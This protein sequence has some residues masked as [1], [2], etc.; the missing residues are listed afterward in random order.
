MDTLKSDQAV[1]FP[2]LPIK[3]AVL[4]PDL[5]MP[6][7]IGRPASLLAVDT[8]L[9]AESRD[10]L[11]LTQR[12]SQI[13][14][15]GPGDVHIVGTLGRIK[16]FTRTG[17]RIDVVIQ[18]ISRVRVDEFT[19]KKPFLQARVSEWRV[20][21]E[22]DAET[23]ALQR[24]L[25]DLAQKLQHIVQP[26]ASISVQQLLQQHPDPLIKAFVLA[27]LSN[28]PIE[29]E[30]KLLEA[31]SVNE[32]LKLTFDQL[33]DE[34][35]IIEIKQ[36]IARDAEVEMT[37]EKKEYLLRQQMRAIQHELGD[38]V[39]N[40]ND[41]DGLRDQ[42]EAAQLP[43]RVMKDAERELRRL[44]RISQSSP[45]Y[46]IVRTYLETL[47][48][49]PWKKS[50]P[51]HFDIA[52]AREILDADHYGIVDVKDRIIEHLAVK[53]LNPAAKAPI[54]CFVGPPG[55]GKTSLGESI[56]RS[57]D[58]P[59]ERLSLGGL[60]D[61][62]ELRGHRRTYIGAMPGRI[63]QAIRKAGL[64]NP[65]IM[66]DELDKL[67]RDYRGDPASALLE[68][69]DPAQNHEFR[70]NYLDCSF[71]LS[72]VFFI[73]TTNSLD[74][75]PRPLLD[76]LEIIRIPGY[77]EDEKIQI[78][79]RY[80]VAR[81]KNEA[82]LA[83]IDVNISDQTLLALIRSYTRESGVRQL[84]RSIG[85]V[86]RKLAVKVA[87]GQIEVKAPNEDDLESLL[88]AA[89]YTQTDVS[90]TMPAG[91]AAGLAW[92]ET[93]GDVLYIEAASLPKDRGITLTGQLGDIMKESAQTALSLVWT[94][95][96]KLHIDPE[97]IRQQGFHIHLPAGAVPKDGPSAGITL[98]VAIASLLSGRPVTPGLAMTGEVTLSG[99]VIAIGG[100][101][102]KILAAH[103]YG[104]RTVLL[105]FENRKDWNEVPES[106]RNEMTVHF[107]RHIDEVFPIALPGLLEQIEN[108][109]TKKRKTNTRTPAVP[110]SRWTYS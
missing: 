25:V 72:K 5:V 55:V 26:N 32:G 23:E 76:R 68:I 102:E 45:D 56:A 74:T 97:T 65:V 48:E 100:L 80:L 82:G 94:S 2:V 50:A 3:N 30:Q 66:L 16:Q 101:K 46:Q 98:V 105:P 63:I 81:Q 84:N 73:A 60:H 83:S 53:K 1:S 47:I 6:L 19:Q 11:V 64:N 14:E 37:R 51:E 62:A 70:D 13:E 44:E 42:L 58:R 18:G 24:S 31:T 35:Q 104:K 29:F 21:Q 43:E 108:K 92:T 85:K 20:P 86:M 109:P 79:K 90:E 88:G 4:F 40:D 57:L 95:A 15:P 12:N 9:N 38:K 67:G 22:V 78:A 7:V 41:A 106:V 8:V 91:V 10:I 107:V 71:D 33:I 93:G 52:R 69:L 36:K 99:R 28:L 75:I 59:F 39:S 87:D 27:T 49:L 89:I 17:D 54:L 96:A 103:R 34:F 61:E 77:T 110:E